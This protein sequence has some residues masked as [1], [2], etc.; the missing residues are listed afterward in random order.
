MQQSDLAN[1]PPDVQAQIA[2]LLRQRGVSGQL[3]SS[4]MTPTPNEVISGRVI[5]TGGGQ[6]LAKLL[7]AYFGNR[8]MEKADEGIAG[9]RQ[10]DLEQYTAKASG[11]TSNPT[12]EALA[13]ALAS[14]DPRYAALASSIQK[15]NDEKLKT[16]AGTVDKIDATTAANA[17]RDDGIPMGSAPT[18]KQPV[19]DMVDDGAGGKTPMVKNYGTGGLVSGTIPAQTRVT[20]TLSPAG[21]A[22]G[23]AAVAT[24]GKI[25]EVVSGAAKTAAEALESV[26]ASDRITELLNT[27]EVISGFAAEPRIGFAAF[28]KLMGWNDGEAAGRSQEMMSALANQTLASVKR[29]PGAITEKERPFLELA[30]AGKIDFNPES[31]QRLADLAKLQGVHELKYARKQ[32]SAGVAEPGAE[33]NAR[34]YPFPEIGA[35]TMDPNRFETVGGPDSDVWQ[36]KALPA[37][38]GA[39]KDR[40]AALEARK[41]ELEAAIEAARKAGKP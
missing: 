2:S 7:S 30:S 5:P 15:R 9:I 4:A 11:L 3:M 38:A 16:W 37:K 28:G 41:A 39:P 32:W 31:L 33:A 17:I 14:G 25:P 26:R 36:R 27:E 40:R 22:E 23:A 8:G 10:K 24:G 34:L 6:I 19:I 35:F 21:K 29:L 1:L 20:Q 13:S 12:R 18:P